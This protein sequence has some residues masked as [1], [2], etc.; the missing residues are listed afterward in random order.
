MGCREDHPPL[1]TCPQCE[2]EPFVRN[3]FFTGKMM[4]AGEFAAETLYHS[5][6][7][8]HH[9]ARLHGWGV[10]CGLKVKQHPSE[11]CRERY[12]V[13][14]PG[15]ALDCCGR[16][17]LVAQDEILDLREHPRV[18]DEVTD[19][20][21]H[22]LQVCVRLRECPSESV[23]VLYDECGCDDEQCAPNRILESFELDVLVDPPL[24]GVELAG[25][26]ALGAFAATDRHGVAGFAGASAAGKISLVDPASD[27]R[28]FLLDPA[29]RSMLTIAPGRA[30][31][32][33]ALSADG[34][35][36]LAAV[37][38]PGAPCRVRIYQAA[39]GVEVVPAPADAAHF[40]IPGSDQTSVLY[41]AAGTGA[42]GLQVYVQGSGKLFRWA[43]D[44]DKG[45]Q[46]AAPAEFTL[47]AG[48]S[49][50][51]ASEPGTALFGI[52]PADGA[53]NRKVKQFTLGASVAVREIAA[54]GKP[55]A[56]APFELGTPARPMLAIASREEKRVYLVDLD[57]PPATPAVQVD[58][59]YPPA[60][61]GATGS[62]DDLWLH[63]FEEH[64]GEAYVQ[65]ISLAPLAAPGGEPLAAAARSAG[66]GTRHIVVLLPRGQAGT[67]AATR[68]AES[69]CADHLW[70]Q[71]GE[72]PECETP[73]CVVLATIPGYQRGMKLLDLPAAPGDLAN[74]IA[75][76]DNKLGRRLLASTATLQSWLECLQLK[77][78]VPGPA[79]APGI[80]GAKGDKGDRGDPGAPGT[81]GPKGDTGDAGPP[82]PGLE[83]DLV[84]LDRISWN[85]DAETN[86][87]TPA[88]LLNSTAQLWGLYIHFTGRVT[89]KDQGWMSLLPNAVEVL[90]PS[91][92]VVFDGTKRNSF[93]ES[94][95]TPARYCF[96][97]ATGVI[98]PCRV[99]GGR[100]QEISGSVSDTWAFV[101][102]S[103]A[104]NALTSLRYFRIK[105]RGDFFLDDDGRAIDAEHARAE[106]PTGDRP[107][108]SKHGIQ[109]GLFESWTWLIQR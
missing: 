42:A 22:T 80:P 61:V 102:S 43:P 54:T 95:E 72:C 29:H 37:V 74:R 92:G 30:V 52:T 5:A 78:G 21:L 20:R 81:P 46:A 103:S 15:S 59:Q 24:A 27:E 68:L 79:G 26:R 38:Q 45:L 28:V 109:G 66:R 50:V 32:A 6:K 63:A 83:L 1:E 107:R 69:D 71:L 3:H 75:R 18:R 19:P 48:L 104:A 44:T 7:M 40:D 57:A 10:V 11:Q 34:N 31:R 64:G 36:V 89:A 51:A 56:L 86:A 73:E 70:K 101:L 60:F 2:L 23:P 35:F 97:D 94:R 90:I 47:E 62:G 12:V 9:N 88:T 100:I 87:L 55:E 16:E 39:D 8:R 96:C 76:I 53:G 65:S 85:H 49:G 84:R 91:Q 33:L 99:A 98:V 14:E 58:L 13:V 105:V 82:G 106:L 4:G 17:I 67:L 77:G 108:N 93:L 25:E 41:A